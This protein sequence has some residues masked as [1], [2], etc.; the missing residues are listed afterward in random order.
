MILC[1][2]PI[3]Y[4]DIKGQYGCRRHGHEK[5]RTALLPL[6]LWTSIVDEL[7]YTEQ[8]F[9]A[10]KVWYIGQNWMEAT[11]HSK[12]MCDKIDLPR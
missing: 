3:N 9:C 11:K 4:I 6:H 2:S 7:F 12:F 8:Q 5:E 10:T 1:Q